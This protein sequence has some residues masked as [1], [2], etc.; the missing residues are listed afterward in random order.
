[1]LSQMIERLNGG[2][3][4]GPMVNCTDSANTVSTFANLVGCDLWQ[5][6][7]GEGFDLNPILAIGYPPPDPWP[8]WDGFTYHEVAW[9]GACTEN[10]RLFDGCLMVDGDNDP[11]NAPHAWLLPT[12]MLF[13]DCTTM[14]YRL[15]LCPP[16]SYG[17]AM[18][19][20]M[21][22]TTRQRRSIG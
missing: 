8:P 2:L 19:Q 6:R 9:K 13:G 18:C 22:T 16:G 21:P 10:E 14:H 17:C 12:D 4:L 20:P 7:M 1:M 3:G 5:S 11:T 15:R